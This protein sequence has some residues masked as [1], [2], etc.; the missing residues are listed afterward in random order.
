MLINPS[1]STTTSMNNP[2]QIVASSSTNGAVLYT[3]PSG[4][5][6]VGYINGSSSTNTYTVTPSGGFAVSFNAYPVTGT[7]IGTTPMPLTFIAGTIITNTG[8][9]TTFLIGVE[10]DL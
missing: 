5:K 8:T 1:P 10:S 6:F 2:R 4:K 3:V 7:S 9:N